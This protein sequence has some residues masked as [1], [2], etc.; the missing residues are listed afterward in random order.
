MKVTI[1]NLKSYSREVQ[2][3]RKN[4]F[5]V[6]ASRQSLVIDNVHDE[7]EVRYYRSLTS[8]DFS[9]S[10]ELDE[11]VEAQEDSILKPE[12]N[13]VD[14][15]KF[16]DYELKRIVKNLGIES[17]ARARWK[18]ESIVKDNLPRDTSLEVYL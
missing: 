16:S 18:L 5:V 1:F 13:E 3:Y 15:S 7:E 10:V 9:V 14:L 6:L 11:T 12:S 8:R 2:Y 17:R 4:K